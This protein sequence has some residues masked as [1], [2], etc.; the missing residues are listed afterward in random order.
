MLHTNM[1]VL[2]DRYEY[3][4]SIP[5]AHSSMRCSPLWSPSEPSGAELVLDSSLFLLASVS[6]FLTF[7]SGLMSS[8]FVGFSSFGFSSVGLSFFS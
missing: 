2:A 1:S 4:T 5:A 7:S 6:G 3:T 8:I